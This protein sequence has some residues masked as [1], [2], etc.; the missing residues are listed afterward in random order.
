MRDRS[1]LFLIANMTLGMG[2]CV[3]GGSGLG[4]VRVKVKSGLEQGEG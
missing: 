2:G 3:M 1:H 4:S